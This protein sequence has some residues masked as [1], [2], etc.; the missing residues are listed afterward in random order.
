MLPIGCRVLA[1]LDVLPSVD[2]GLQPWYAEVIYAF[3]HPN[4]GRVPGHDFDLIA[5]T[6]RANGAL[7]ME[8]SPAHHTTIK[9]FHDFT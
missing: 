1:Y 6:D 8:R 7:G 2:V 9:I 3:L 4:P 5:L